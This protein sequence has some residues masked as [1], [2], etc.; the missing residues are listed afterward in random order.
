MAGARHDR[1]HNDLYRDR[2]L[3]DRAGRLITTLDEGVRYLPAPDGTALAYAKPDGQRSVVVDAAT[4]SKR[5]L[6]GKR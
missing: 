5:E 4:G 2:R 1:S 3:V 6:A